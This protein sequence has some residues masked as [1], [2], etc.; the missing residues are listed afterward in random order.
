MSEKLGIDVSPSDSGEACIDGTDIVIT[1]T[2]TSQPVLFGEWL[3]PGMHINA[4]G[5]NQWMRREL[6][7]AA[8][9]KANVIVTDDVEQAKAECGDI[10][11]PAETGQVRWD[12]VRSLSG[13][14]GGRTPGRTSEDDFTLF[15]SQGIALEDIAAGIKIYHIARE[16][17][18]GTELPF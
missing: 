5:A 2:S 1:M 11:F 9:S 10:L 16:R 15:E 17:G 14:I 18:I 12:Q 3:Q 7:E 6:D 13:V 4:A 8:V